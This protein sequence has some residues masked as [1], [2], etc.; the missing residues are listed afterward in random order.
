MSWLWGVSSWTLRLGELETI[1]CQLGLA[2]Q[3][4]P[5][6]E[7]VCLL[8]QSQRCRLAKMEE[9]GRLCFAISQSHIG[10]WLGFQPFMFGRTQ[11]LSCPCELN[12]R[13]WIGDRRGSVIVFMR[14]ESVF[15]SHVRLSA[16]FGSMSGSRRSS[17]R[18]VIPRSFECCAL[19]V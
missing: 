15:L 19:F 17:C 8:A 10:R 2:I 5:R 11:I 12:K 13:K 3:L 1:P 18:S 16:Y 14:V 4:A 6:F 9:I 7:F